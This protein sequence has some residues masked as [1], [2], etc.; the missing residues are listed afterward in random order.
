MISRKLDD[1]SLLDHT[2]MGSVGAAHDLGS[3]IL[4]FYKEGRNWMD[5]VYLKQ[6]P[7]RGPYLAARRNYMA[8]GSIKKFA[9]H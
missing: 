1:R 9:Y 3:I 6:P 7:T 4:D 5:F 2:F 8:N